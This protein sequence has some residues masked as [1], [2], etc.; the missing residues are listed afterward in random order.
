[1]YLDLSLKE[2]IELVKGDSAIAVVVDL[3]KFLTEALIQLIP[4]SL[5]LYLRFR[6]LDVRESVL[7]HG[8]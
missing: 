8:I 3:S 1:M 6:S 5:L 7:E 4:F 2:V